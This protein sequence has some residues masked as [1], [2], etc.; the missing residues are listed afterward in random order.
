MLGEREL[1]AFVG[2]K[3]PSRARAFYRDTLG[4]KLTSENNFA[5]V[6][7]CHGV[8]LRVTTVPEMTPAPYT[9]LGWHVPDIAEA[10]REMTQAGVTFER[11]PGLEQDAQGIWAAPGGTLVAWFKDPDGNTLG[12]QQF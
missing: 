5:L 10:V 11:Y 7:D 2:T 8:M 9:V 1:V 4:L 6:F 3:D 12:I